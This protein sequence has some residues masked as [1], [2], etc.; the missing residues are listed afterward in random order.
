MSEPTSTTVIDG[1]SGEKHAPAKPARQSR[2]A[3]G[4]AQAK[5][6]STARKPAP[7]KGATVTQIKPK[8]AKPDGVNSEKNKIAAAL[9]DHV[10]AWVTPAT[11]KKIGVPLD[12]LAA[13]CG[14]AMSYLPGDHWARSLTSPGTSRGRRHVVK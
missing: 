14:R 9:I 1:A 4:A 7:A 2:A 3:R 8:A 6:G 12:V 13:E 10:G 11:A 5:K